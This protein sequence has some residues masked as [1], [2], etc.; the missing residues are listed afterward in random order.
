MKGTDMPTR[1]TLLLL[2]L[3]TLPTMAQ[4]AR[5]MPPAAVGCGRNNLTAYTGDVTSYSRK[6]GKI[7][8]TMKTD[9]ST[10]ETVAFEPGDK[11]L[12]NAE[13]MREGEWTKVEV[14]EGR[15]KAG[16]RATAWI[17]RGGRP[18]LDWQPPQR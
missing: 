14:K 6:G 2:A 8:L 16:M 5:Y 4:R 11:I 12:L 1:L 17:C 9:E 18:V 13:V 10:V 7:R 3:A 15:L